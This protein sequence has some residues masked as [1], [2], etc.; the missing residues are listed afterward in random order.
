MKMSFACERDHREPL[1]IPPSTARRSLELGRC[2]ICP[3][4]QLEGDAFGGLDW[5]ECP[6]CGSHWRLEDERYALRPGRVVE[7]WSES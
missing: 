5:A 3:T 7:E 2:P 4:Q 6:C 1:P